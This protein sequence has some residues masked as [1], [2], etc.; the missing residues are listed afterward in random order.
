M[1]NY[2]PVST[3]PIIGN[4]F[5]KV[6]YTRL[7]KYFTSLGILHRKQF[8]FCKKIALQIILLIIPQATSKK[9]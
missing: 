9:L 8:G 4:I 3:L 2:R 7:Y 6:I 1:K 5:E